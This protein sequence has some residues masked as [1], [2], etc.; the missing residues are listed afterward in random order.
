MNRANDDAHEHRDF[1]SFTPAAA[2][3]ALPGPQFSSE[4][5]KEL[6]AALEVPFDAS[7]IVW[8]VTNTSRDKSRGQVIPY[9]DQRA[10]TDRLERTVHSSGMDTQIHDPHERKL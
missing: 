9:A 7:Q 3:A 6:I 8:R 5:V 10:Y 1:P 4:R 2:L